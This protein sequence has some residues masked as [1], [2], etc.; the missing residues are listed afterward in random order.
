LKRTPPTALKFA[1]LESTINEVNEVMLMRAKVPIE[2]TPLGMVK[3][4]KAVNRKAL[5][6]IVCNE[7]GKE[8]AFS[9]DAP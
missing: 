3:L 5:A 1:L 6:P 4:V 2:F 7:L 9:D 8:I